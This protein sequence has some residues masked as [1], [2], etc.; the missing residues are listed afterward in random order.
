MKK[1]WLMVLIVISLF[2]L[3]LY[4]V[5]PE[6][7]LAAVAGV[8]WLWVGVAL[9]LNIANIGVE[10]LR[11]QQLFFSMEKRPRFKRVFGAF[12]VGFF[13]NI[14]FPLRV[15]DG[16]R[17]YFLSRQEKIKAADVIWTFLLD[18]I[19]DILFFLVLIGVTGLYFPLSGETEK[20]FHLLL[21]ALSLSVVVASS[22]AYLFSRGALENLSGWRKRL[23]KFVDRL[24]LMCR[25]LFRAKNLSFVSALAVFSWFLRVLIIFM[26]LKAFNLP[27]PF[28]ASVIAVIMVNLGLAAVNT[29]ANVGGFEVALVAALKLFAVDTGTALSCALLLHVVEVVPVFLMGGAVVIKTGFQPGRAKKEARE[30]EARIEEAL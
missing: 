17:V 5:R 9:V 18:R 19:V 14:L 20:A 22:L 25:S 11:W 10:S 6:R 1:T 28:V 12:L 15:G 24:R 23:R 21:L 16:F 30:I 13:G 27:L 7:L 26:M 8:N 2:V 3:V 4:K 29:P